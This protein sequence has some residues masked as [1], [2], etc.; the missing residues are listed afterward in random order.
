MIGY[1]FCMICALYKLN[2]F[3]YFL[4]FELHVLSLTIEVLPV[5]EGYS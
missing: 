5:I 3:Q 1:H 2:V 4:N